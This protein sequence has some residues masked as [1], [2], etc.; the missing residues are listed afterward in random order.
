MYL[1]IVFALL[2]DVAAGGECLGAGAGDDDAADSVV[3]VQR[4]HRVVQFGRQLAVHRVQ[5]VG[6]VQR[7]D[8]DAV[9]HIDQDVFVA[10]G[11]LRR[12][13]LSLR[14]AQR[15]GNAA[16]NAPRWREIAASLRSS[17]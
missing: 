8:A 15:R 3:G 2:V 10:H 1:T 14:G 16:G 13:G 17:R 9:F 11:F 12:R 5:L 4:L 6:A 7:D